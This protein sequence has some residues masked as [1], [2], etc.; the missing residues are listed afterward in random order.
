MVSP[1]HFREIS[2]IAETRER[3]E[4][5]AL[6]ETLGMRIE[7]DFRGIKK[8]AEEFLHLGLGVADTAHVA[9]AEHAKASFISCDDRLL[10]KCVK[11]DL[12]IWVGSPLA[13][14]EKENLK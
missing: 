5:E 4:L 2:D 13:F 8:R 6:L 10:K 9:F 3:V 11:A 1:V 12:G 14:C 7:G